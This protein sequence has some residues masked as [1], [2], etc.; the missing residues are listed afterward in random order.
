LENAVFLGELLDPPFQGG[1]LGERGLDSVAGDH[2]LGIAELAH[3]FPDAL[4]LGEYFLLCAAE[5]RF[6]VEWAFAPR[7]LDPFVGPDRG[8]VATGLAVGG[9]LLDQHPGVRVF[10]EE[11]GGHC[12]PVGDGPDGESAAFATQLGDVPVRLGRACPG[13]A[14]GG[15]R[16]PPQS[17]RAGSPSAGPTSTWPAASTG[18][19]TRPALRHAVAD[20]AVGRFDILPITA[21]DRLGRDMRTVVTLLADLDHAGV[22]VVT[23]DGAVNTRSPNGRFVLAVLTAAVEFQTALGNHRDQTGRRRRR[24]RARR[25]LPGCD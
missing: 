3:Q 13:F 18:R 9:G 5:F 14:G 20:A 25:R 1:V 22:A 24:R 8:A 23:A 11:R 6:G 16:W 2:L 19:Q 10:V 15:R 4:S 12:C 7:R 17:G 21:I